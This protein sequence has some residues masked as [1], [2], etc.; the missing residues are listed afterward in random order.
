[1]SGK[2]KPLLESSFMSGIFGTG[3]T[4]PWEGDKFEEITTKQGK[5]ISAGVDGSH[6]FIE[7]GKG[8][9]SFGN[10]FDSSTQASR[11]NNY[12]KMQYYPEVDECIDNI[13]NDIITSETDRLPIELDFKR[14]DE[15]KHKLSDDVKTKMREAHEKVMNLLGID[16]RPAEVI[17][18]FY[19]DGKQAWQIILSDK[20]NGGIDRIVPLESSS[21][22]KVKMIKVELDTSTGIEFVSE[23]RSSFLYDSKTFSTPSTKLHSIDLNQSKILE[24]PLESIA[25]ADSDMFTPDG[26]S[27]VGFLEPAVKPANNLNTVED[28]TVIYSITRAIDKRAFFIDVGD[29]PTKSAEQVLQT[30]M[31]KFKT[32]LNYNQQTGS[33]DNNKTN[34]SMVEDLFIARRNGTNVADIQTLEG[35]RNI[36]ETN[37]IQYFREKVYTA[38]KI[39]RARAREESSSINI[40]GSDFGEV[41]RAEYKFGNHVKRIRK[42]YTKIIKHLLHV[43]LVET[44][45]LTEK[46]WKIF[47]P[48]IQFEFV[49]DS[50]IVEQQQNE[51]AATRIDLMQSVEP[52]I[53]KV[54]SIEYLKKRI[55]RMSEEEIEDM[56]TQIEEEKAKGLYEEYG[57]SPLKMKPQDNPNGF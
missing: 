24:L 18:Q 53:G 5:A 46:E 34:L 51:T 49:V 57:E 20:T 55:L 35:G 50:Y 32:K 19:V 4:L 48:L 39:P 43:E 47:E 40:G 11:I 36:G 30:S 13:V 52:Y 6:T 15:S 37:H 8:L 16:E 9:T 7:G 54:F 56:A 27:V 41:S 21:I 31:N 45:I 14:I 38:L 25:Y 10:N 12:R 1:M 23:E 3:S 42:K 44:N 22:F 17:R 26:R 28:S 29:L 33:V 2:K